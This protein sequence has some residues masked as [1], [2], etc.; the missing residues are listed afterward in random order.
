MSNRILVVDDEPHIRDVITFALERAGM[1]VS[2]ARDGSEALI[3]WRRTSPDLIVL[4]IGMPEL[5]GLDVCRQIRKTSDVPIL[6]L[7]ARDEEVDR[8]IG[9]EIG[10]DDYVSKPF[11]PRELVARVKTI[12]KRTSGPSTQAS[13][14]MV[15]GPLRLDRSAHSVIWK[16]T[17]IVLTALEFEVLSALLGR[18]E[19]VFSR[20]QLMTTAY[21][22]DIH[23]SERTIDSHIRNLRA[24]F[25]AAGCGAAVTTVHGVGFKLGS[26][27]PD[28]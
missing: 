27:E 24:K 28:Q 23:V 1:A 7:S 9:L 13:D 19:M 16:G 10:G 15:R 11:S 22:G 2:I 5:D 8:I 18:P 17:P 4:D 20:E 3:A 25:A 14:Q 21:G 26:M 6:F 12:L